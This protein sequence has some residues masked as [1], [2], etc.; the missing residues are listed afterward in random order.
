MA[1]PSLS[2]GALR[3]NT[4]Q[5]YYGWRIVHTLGITELLSWGIIYYS[6]GVLL[7]PMQNELG[8]SQPQMTGAFAIAMILSGIAAVPAGR[9]LDQAGARWLMTAGSSAA[10]LLVLAW[11][12]VTTLT[13]FYF[14]WAGLGVT[15]ALVLYEPAFAVVTAWFVHQRSQALTLL[16]IWGGLASVVCIPLTTMLIQ[17]VGWR[18]ALVLL[19]LL[20]GIVTVPLHALVLRRRPADIGWSVDGQPAAAGLRAGKHNP[21]SALHTPTDISVRKA[22]RSA[23]FWWLA[24]AFALG[25]SAAITINVHLLSYLLRSGYSSSLAASAAGLIGA[26]Q[27]P[28]RMLSALLGHRISH[29]TMVLIL[30]ALQIG[31]LLLLLTVAT[32]TGVLTFAAL[33]GAGAGAL[34]P[35]RAA[36][37]AD[38]YGSTHYGSISGSIAFTT[39]LARACAPLGASLLVSAAG[40]YRSLLWTLTVM[41]ALSAGATALGWALRPHSLVEEQHQ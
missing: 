20:L 33:F 8:W 9:I 1:R 38:I 39:T 25:T 41:I 12:Q 36:L 18:S 30:S 40:S 29:R 2:A 4:P 27:I 15:M 14:I 37:V 5:R 34:T 31:A 28:S 13:G 22:L 16:T 26:A 17:H 32:T 10:T 3:P 35:T 11:S 6:F 21:A 19:A 24:L 23:S 7:T